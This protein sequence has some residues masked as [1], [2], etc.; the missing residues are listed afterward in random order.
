[1]I[2]EMIIKKIISERERQDILHKD[3]RLDDYLSILIEEIGEVAKA[4]QS[5]DIDNLKEEL[6]QS[7]AVIIRWLEDIA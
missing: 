5:N 1:M 7:A 3:N 4:I 6:I 2:Q